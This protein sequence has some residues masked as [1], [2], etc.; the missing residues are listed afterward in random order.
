MEV[1]YVFIEGGVDGGGL[2][3]HGGGLEE[4]WKG[5]LYL[6]IKMKFK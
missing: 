1:V 3:E 2:R 6:K 4:G 5:E